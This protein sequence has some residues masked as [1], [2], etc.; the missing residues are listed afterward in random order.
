MRHLAL[1][2][3][4]PG[5]ILMLEL[6]TGLLPWVCTVNIP[7]LLT[8][9]IS[10]RRARHEHRAKPSFAPTTAPIMAATTLRGAGRTYATPI[11]PQC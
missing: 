7:R 5:L 11:P 2:I 6:T 4:L 10:P 8:Q 1:A 9:H 3:I